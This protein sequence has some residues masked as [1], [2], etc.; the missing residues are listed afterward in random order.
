MQEERPTKYHENHFKVL[1]FFVKSLL[2]KY[3]KTK[4]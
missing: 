1:N 3:C 4:F 2:E